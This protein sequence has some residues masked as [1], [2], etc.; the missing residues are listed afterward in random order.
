MRSL[1]QETLS[2]LEEIRQKINKA[3]LRFGDENKNV[4]L[5]GVSKTIEASKIEDIIKAGLNVFGENRVQEAFKKWPE[6][7][8]KYPDIKLHLIGPL[9]TNKVREA[10]KLFDVIETL[11]REKL[12]KKLR[13]EMDLVK[14]ELPIFVQVNIGDEPQKAGIAIK[15]TVEFVKKCQDIYKLNIVG[16]M[17]IPP[18]DIA[19]APYFAQLATLAQEAGLKDLSMGMSKDYEI[20]IYMGASYVRVGSALFGQRK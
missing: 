2:A 16:L 12:A 17:A 6:L 5:V 1:S 8:L 14:K 10:V 3:K 13:T 18:A 7:K 15:E 19:P 11:D 20:A 9:Q 4:E